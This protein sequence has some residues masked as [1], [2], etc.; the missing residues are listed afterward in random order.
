MW[1]TGE[2]V[3]VSIGGLFLLVGLFL[4]GQGFVHNARLGRL[5]GEEFLV[6]A[7]VGTYNVGSQASRIKETKLHGAVYLAGAI[8]LLLYAYWNHRWS[9][10]WL[11]GILAFAACERFSKQMVP[12]SILVLG[13][14]EKHAL[15]LQEHLNE[16]L[17]PVRALSLLRTGPGREVIERPD[18][19]RLGEADD[20][21]EA[22]EK[23]C[24]Y[25]PLVICDLRESTEA[26]EEEIRL[27]SRKQYLFKTVFVTPGGQREPVL[28]RARQSNATVTAEDV[29]CVA[30]E[31]EC[32]RLLQGVLL[33]Q[34]VAPTRERPLS[35]RVESHTQG[36]G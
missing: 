14:S 35:R 21:M 27:L 2:I 17:A 30:D 36:A 16:R 28:E 7:D 4:L 1:T 5:F 19:F 32:T 34:N 6:Y 10:A 29:V 22:V 9:L 8:G 26:V 13:R 31:V 15:A 12:G 3:S 23:L 11:M 33:G 25:L 24:A 20:W 18:C